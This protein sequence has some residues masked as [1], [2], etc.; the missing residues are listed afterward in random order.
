MLSPINSLIAHNYWNSIHCLVGSQTAKRFH[1]IFWRYFNEKFAFYR[2]AHLHGVINRPLLFVWLS[3]SIFHASILIFKKWNMLS[4]LLVERIIFVLKSQFES[5][6]KTRS[7]ESDIFDIFSFTMK[8]LDFSNIF[9][10]IIFTLKKCFYSLKVF[11]FK[12]NIFY[13]NINRLLLTAF[14]F[15][16]FFGLLY[17]LLFSILIDSI[18]ITKTFSIFYVCILWHINPLELS[19]FIES[20]IT[21]TIQLS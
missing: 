10:I 5:V 15:F 8:M 4:A 16:E 1:Y 18:F 6:P 14:F 17:K 21:N 9:A 7:F 11:S 19:A 2:I 3:I 12:K 20:W 13:V